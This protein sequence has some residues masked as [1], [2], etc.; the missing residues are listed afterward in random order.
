MEYCK[1]CGSELADY[2]PCL[3]CGIVNDP[4]EQGK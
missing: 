2:G 3:N 1:N 4:P